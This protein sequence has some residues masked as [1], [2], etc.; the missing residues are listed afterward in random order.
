MKRPTPINNRQ[1]ASGDNF[2]TGVG[3]DERGCQPAA[4]TITVLSGKWKANVKMRAD[5]CAVV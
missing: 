4:V 5:N 3:S 2:I 1:L